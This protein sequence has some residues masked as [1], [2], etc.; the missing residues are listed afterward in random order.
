MK[1]QIL[2]FL[3]CL[4]WEL[5]YVFL[6]HKLY[7][8]STM[9]F[10]TASLF[11]IHSSSSDAGWQN[12]MYIGSWNDSEGNL[13]KLA[14]S[15]LFS[16]ILCILPLSRKVVSTVRQSILP[17]FGQQ[18]SSNMCC[19][20]HN[21]RYSLRK[22]GFSQSEFSFSHCFH[23]PHLPEPQL[24][25]SNEGKTKQLWFTIKCHRSPVRI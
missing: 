15:C 21:I 23:P 18:S 14:F 1:K 8:E 20:Q 11:C 19:P 17:F 25:S 16:N 7:L 3:G 12:G 9:D 6:Y 22:P 13:P 5:N 2:P 24:H 4:S 10:S